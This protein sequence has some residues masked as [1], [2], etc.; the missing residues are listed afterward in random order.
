MEA[1][2][3]EGIPHAFVVDKAGDIA[4]HGHPM[5]GLDKVLDAM[6]AGTYDIAAEKKAQQAGKL[7]GQYAQLVVAGEDPERAAKLGDA[8]LKDAGSN[9]QLMNEFAWFILTEERVK[10][11]DLALAMRVA[12]AALDACN[13]KDAAIVDTYARALF[14]TGKKADAIK[15]QRQA[16]ELCKDPR[17]KAELEKTLK[18]YLEKAK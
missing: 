4:W 13:G 6:I 14:D 1:F 18:E 12:K 5:A 10:N 9:A 8:I 2:R 16:I 17:M 3:V 15:F 7:L 11:R